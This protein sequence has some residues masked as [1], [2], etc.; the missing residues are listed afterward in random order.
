MTVPQHQRS[1][2]LKEH[3]HEQRCAR[4]LRCS[5]NSMCGQSASGASDSSKS[6]LAERTTNSSAARSTR[7]PAAP[8]MV[9]AFQRVACSRVRLA[10]VCKKQR[11][12]RG[13][14]ARRAKHQTQASKT[15]HQSR[16]APCTEQRRAARRARPMCPPLRAAA[17]PRGLGARRTGVHPQTRR[18]AVR[19]AG[20]RSVRASGRRRARGRHG[21]PASPARAQA[22]PG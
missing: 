1:M 2:Y 18:R 4:P 9:E 22:V 21:S 17:H 15:G 14:R 20:M 11:H 10:D 13:P 12:E 3:G 7:V 16:R 6:H 19:Q 5:G 8:S